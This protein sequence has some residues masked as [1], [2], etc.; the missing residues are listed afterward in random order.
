MKRKLEKSTST[1]ESKEEISL[2]DNYKEL[3]F[4]KNLGE[5]GDTCYENDGM[6]FNFMFFDISPKDKEKLIKITHSGVLCVQNL[7]PLN[8]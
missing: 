1:E 6:N 2:L 8:K 3:G 7:Y 4:I 5:L